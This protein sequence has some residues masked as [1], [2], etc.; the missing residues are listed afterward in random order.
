MH[1]LPVLH[2]TSRKALWNLFQNEQAVRLG[3]YLCEL[4]RRGHTN[5]LSTFDDHPLADDW[6]DFAWQSLK[7]HFSRT[8]G[9]VYVVTNPVHVNL[10]K[11]GQTRGAVGERIKSL[12]SAGVV[13]YFVPVASRQVADRFAVEVAVRRAL[14]LKEGRQTHKEFV[15]CTW[16]E[17]IAALEAETARETEVLAQFKA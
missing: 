8:E 16:E 10:Y 5:I 13:G 2:P 12:D 4:A 17:A 11:I 7:E 15:A 3:T 1:S 14:R 6:Q 9:T